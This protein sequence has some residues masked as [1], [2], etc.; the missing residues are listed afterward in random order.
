M[1]NTITSTAVS[2]NGHNSDNTAIA[3]HVTAAP[4]SDPRSTVAH[5]EA[6]SLMVTP[7]MD[8]TSIGPWRLVTADQEHVAIAGKRFGRLHRHRTTPSP[9]TDLETQLVIVE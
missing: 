1:I 4:P 3:G 7:A 5:D 9:S 8:P 6:Q 2:I